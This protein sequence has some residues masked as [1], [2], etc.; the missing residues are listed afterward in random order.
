MIRPQPISFD[1]LSVSLAVLRVGFEELKYVV[2]EGDGEVE[3]CLNKSTEV[4]IT[5]Q[6]RVTTSPA[7]AEGSTT[8][9]VYIY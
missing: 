4:D 8:V 1:P 6:L 3:V 5:F 7:T 9:Y 2:Q